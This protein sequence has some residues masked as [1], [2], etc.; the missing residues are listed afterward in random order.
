[1]FFENSV[2]LQQ[3]RFNSGDRSSIEAA[4]VELLIFSDFRAKEDV[5]GSDLG[6]ELA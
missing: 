6:I 1:M 3:S 5:A 4:G 2:L